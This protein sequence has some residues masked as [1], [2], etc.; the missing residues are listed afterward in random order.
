MLSNGQLLSTATRHCSALGVVF[1]PSTTHF[2]SSTTQKCNT[3]R[4]LLLFPSTTNCTL[5]VLTNQCCLM[6]SQQMAWAQS[7]SV[8]EANEVAA[9]AEWILIWNL[10]KIKKRM[11]VHWS[12]SFFQRDVHF[13][14]QF[15]RRTPNRKVTIFTHRDLDL[16]FEVEHTSLKHH[17]ICFF[18]LYFALFFVF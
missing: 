3:S 11:I 18:S 8:N 1:W 2:L 13:F 9:P 7:L 12:K 16:I 5:P 6:A 4:R 14:Q 17:P 15:K 10:K